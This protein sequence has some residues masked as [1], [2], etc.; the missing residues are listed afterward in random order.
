VLVVAAG[1]RVV[2]SQISESAGDHAEEKTIIAAAYEA[3]A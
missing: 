2:Y 3:A 1:G